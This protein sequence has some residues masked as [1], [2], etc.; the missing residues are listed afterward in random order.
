[1]VHIAIVEDQKAEA[2]L[3]MD[4]I[5]RFSCEHGGQFKVTWFPDGEDILEE[6]K[7]IYDIVFIDIQLQFIDGMT[8]AEE[9]RKQ[10]SKVILIFVTKIAQYAIKGYSVDALHYLL[11]PLT[12]FAF[13]MQMKRSLD[14]LRKRAQQFVILPFASGAVRI[15]C[16]DIIYVES[17]RHVMTFHT[18]EGP[19]SIN[20]TM[21]E[22]EEKLSGFG[23][24]RCNSCYLV[25]LFHVKSINGNIAQVGDFELVISRAR[26]KPFLEALTRYVGTQ[27]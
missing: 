5:D 15:N 27:L 10:D 18:T 23:F 11:K 1:M 8:T 6:Y 7:P 26:K 14:K 13:S 9:I 12:Y 17:D 21:R 3:L 2:R 20:S 4:Y 16:A 22:L 24:F 25:N 19:Q